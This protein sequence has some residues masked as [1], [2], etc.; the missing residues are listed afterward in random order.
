MNRRLIGLITAVVLAAVATALLIQYV[1]SA[2][3]RA[4]QEEQLAQVFVAQG[5][6]QP[7]ISADDAISQGLIAEEEVPARAVPSGAVAQLDQIRGQIVSVPIYD[8]EVIVSQRFGESVAQATGLLQVPEGTQAVT[9]EAGV[10]PG[11]A[12]Y[13][14]PGNV[15]SV[16]GS[17][18]VPAEDSLAGADAVPDT[19]LE[20]GNAAVFQTQYLVQNATVLAVGRRVPESDA[21]EGEANTEASSERYLFT[22]AMPPEDIE[23]L[24]FGTQRGSLWFTLVPEGE[25]PEAEP[26]V[27]DAPGRSVSSAFE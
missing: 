1:R 27:F 10:V 14:Q 4:R 7:G 23:K 17:L 6:I 24:V 5:D 19:I 16:V 3:E 25:D 22:L 2:D 11:L 13:V 8:G 18:A 15:V 21:P 20:N 26:E 9:V 12:G